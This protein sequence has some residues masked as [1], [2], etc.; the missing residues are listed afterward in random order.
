MN[1][2]DLESGAN[3]LSNGSAGP[4]F[5]EIPLEQ[6]SGLSDKKRAR[7]WLADQG[8]QVLEDLSAFRSKRR[9]AALNTID[10]IFITEIYQNTPY[11]KT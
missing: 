7:I 4:S 2:R 9:E 6:I 1:P 3:N 10:P 11:D 8:H 5:S